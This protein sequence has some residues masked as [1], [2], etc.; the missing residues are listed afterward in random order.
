MKLR[1]KNCLATTLCVFTLIATS[2]TSFAQESKPVLTLENAIAAAITHSNELSLNSKEAELLKEKMK[3]NE[4]TTFYIYQNSYLQRAKNEQQRQIIQDKVT[5][6]ITNRYQTLILG[7]EELAHLK[8]SLAIKQTEFRNLTL[9][10]ELGLVSEVNYKLAQ[11]EIIQLKE[12]I[13]A[14]TSA[15]HN[16]QDYF[17]LLTTKDPKDYT[18]DKT[19]NYEIFRAPGTIDSYLD[20][21]IATYLQYDKEMVSLAANNIIKDGDA[22]MAWNVYLEQKYAIESKSHTLES[23]QDSLKNALMTSYSSLISLEEQIAHLKMQME[24]LDTQLKSSALQV[25]LG[26]QT[27]LSHEKTSLNKMQLDY[28]LRQLIVNYNKLKTSIQKP[29]TAM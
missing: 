8:A 26:L 12:K 25:D 11:L 20:D 21:R 14:K 6:D 4:G 24:I 7:E 29:W 28:N 9:Q 18:L 16:Q 19:L 17:K 22:P 1:F 27:S 23:S 13:E 15:L 5:Y 10:K 3:A 2:L